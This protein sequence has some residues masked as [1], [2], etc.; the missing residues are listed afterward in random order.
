MC[1]LCEER[2]AFAN[3]AIEDILETHTEYSKHMP[4]RTQSQR[5]TDIA[6]MWLSDLPFPENTNPKTVEAVQNMTL[7]LAAM[8]ERVL[9][10]R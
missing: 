7:F 10:V 9:D 2:F 1:V 5:V 4:E 3:M 8:T 6:N